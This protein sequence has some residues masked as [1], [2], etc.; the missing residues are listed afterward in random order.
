MLLNTNLTSFKYLHRD[1]LIIIN[2]IIHLQL[3]PNIIQ[4]IFPKSNTVIVYTVTV[5]NNNNNNNNNSNN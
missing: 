3:V 4:T 2:K 5:T 1:F